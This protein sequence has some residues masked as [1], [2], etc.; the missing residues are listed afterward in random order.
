MPLTPVVGSAG[1]WEDPDLAA[2]GGLHAFLVGVSAY[3]HLAGGAAPAAETFGL[4]QLPG[5]ARTAAELAAWL[6]DEYRGGPPLRRLWLHL[7]PDPQEL[8]PPGSEP[9]AGA[10]WAALEAGLLE[11]SAALAALSPEVAA[12]SA[13]L[14][15]FAGHGVEFGPDQQLLLPAGWPEPTRA[16]ALSV[17]NL[18]D[19]LS[20]LPVATQWFFLDACRSGDSVLRAA[21]GTGTPVLD[22]PPADADLPLVDQPVLSATSR[23]RPAYV[24]LHRGTAFG[25]GLLEGLRGTED[26]VLSPDPAT[27]LQAVQLHQLQAYLNRRVRELLP[28]EATP[29]RVMLGGATSSPTLVVS[30]VPGPRPRP[31]D[32]PAPS[33]LTMGPAHPLPRVRLSGLLP[34]DLPDPATLWH[35]AHEAF[36]HEFL[37]G[38]WL[39]ARL[40]RR[41]GGAWVPTAHRLLDVDRDPDAH[42]TRVVLE[43]TTS[44]RLFRFRLGP[45]LSLLP[46]AGADRFLLR[47]TAG[48]EGFT[49]FEATFDPD[50]QG[51]VG[52]VARA[53]EAF[54]DASP[55]HGA[56]A[57]PEAELE[58][59]VWGKVANP[60]AAAVAAAILARAGRWERLHDWVGVLCDRF[61]WLPDGAALRAWQLAVDAS[62]R[63]AGRSFARWEAARVA[64]RGLAGRGLPWT[65]EAARMADDALRRAWRPG[66]APEPELERLSAGL[67]AALSRAEAGSLFTTLELR[68]GDDPDALLELRV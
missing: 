55:T 5:A 66:R 31:P 38:P 37:T 59:A 25:L 56:A 39:Q 42:E 19:H 51:A 10:D 28:P 35:T 24:L 27:G 45:F 12:R 36:G 2:T 65:T 63:D 48:R 44:A 9:H 49:G 46:G 13:A 11:W 22:T 54:R 14:F 34:L 43:A 21:V 57:L 33:P 18:R 41:E 61:P 64:L 50:A 62:R 53:W 7:A 26:I 58:R 4:E 68:P 8:L 67:G 52:L 20:A 30:A 15:F 23:G 16:R 60:V 6:R 17:Q 47:V 1:R 32:L 29:P 3:P 40:E